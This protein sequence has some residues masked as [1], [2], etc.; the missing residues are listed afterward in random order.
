MSR[1]CC[2]AVVGCCASWVDAAVG[3]APVRPKMV[4][5]DGVGV[6]AR[7]LVVRSGMVVVLAEDL[8]VVDWA[9]GAW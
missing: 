7:L 4:V 2:G 1:V 5:G 6:L 8:A 3:I 9:V